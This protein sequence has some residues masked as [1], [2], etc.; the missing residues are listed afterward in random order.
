MSDTTDHGDAERDW[1]TLDN[2]AKI[3]P[4]AHT[5]A[6][7]QVFRLSVSLDSPIR[8]ARLQTA[9]ERMIVRCPYFR[10][11]LKRGVFWYYLERCDALPRIE[12]LADEPISG[13]AIRR[14][15]DLLFRVLARDATVAIDFSHIL[16]D[17]HGAM[18]FLA[19]LIAEY[20]RL[21]GEPIE[22]DPWLLDPDDRPAAGESEDAYRRYFRKRVSKPPEL[23]PAYHVPG[24]PM[25]G[26]R[27]VTGRLPVTEALATAKRYG[28]TLTEY[29]TAVYIEGVVERHR[30]QRESF[31]RPRKSVIRIEVPV[32]MRRLFPSGS[33]RNFSLFVSP[34]IDLALG[35]YSFDEIVKIV[36]HT[37]NVQ[38]DPRQLLRQLGRNVAGELNPFVRVVP[39]FLKDIY[40]SYL[41]YRLGDRL[42]SGVISNLGRFSFPASVEKHVKSV[43]FTLG[44]NPVRK[45][46][47]AVVS[48]GD[49]L[50]I[51]FGSM[52]TGREL[53]RS[54]FRRLV[55][56]GNAVTVSE[57][58]G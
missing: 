39:L 24:F 38:L 53:E 51:S 50:S 18:R 21:S 33:M 47:C 31:I 28:A 42:Y 32:N 12:P 2:A 52:I 37:M 46:D 57:V 13:F 5:D 1:F 56:D 17:G 7:P 3:Y 43:G 19:S 55:E 22:S 15:H 44:R 35:E 10:V 6:M 14:T 54:F 23:G 4:A 16:T 8:I 48:H 27:V 45:K 26:Y 25:P 34:E 36:H 49:E 30:H 58:G 11:H 20:L 41:H 40:L 9:A 29:L